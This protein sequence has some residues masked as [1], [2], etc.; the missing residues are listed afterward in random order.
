METPIMMAV[1]GALIALVLYVIMRY[2]LGQSDQVAQARS[3]LVGLVAAAYMVV[4]GHNVPPM[5]VNPAL[6]M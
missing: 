2:A 1:H 3:V 4:F 5:G 6:G